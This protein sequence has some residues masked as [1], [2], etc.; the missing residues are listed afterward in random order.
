MFKRLTRH[1]GLLI[2][3]LQRPLFAPDVFFFAVAGIDQCC[4]GK[5]VWKSGLKHVCLHGENYKIGLPTVRFFDA[6]EIAV[7]LYLCSQHRDW[8]RAP[9]LPVHPV[10]FIFRPWAPLSY[11]VA[12]PYFFREVPPSAG[13]EQKAG[14][15]A[16][17]WIFGSG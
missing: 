14:L 6:Q 5:P 2:V 13:L 10:A 4:S 17:F 15:S 12:R 11:L 9:D 7:P 8:E 16:R 3:F 1:F